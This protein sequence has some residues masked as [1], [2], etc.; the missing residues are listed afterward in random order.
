VKIIH[1]LLHAVQ[2]FVPLLLLGLPGIAAE[3]PLQILVRLMMA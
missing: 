3:Q 1:E 2:S